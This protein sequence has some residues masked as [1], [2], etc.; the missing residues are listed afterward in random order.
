MFYAILSGLH[1]TLP[2]AELRGILE[3]LGQKYRI[4]GELDLLVLYTSSST[5]SRG[6]ASRAG[7]VHETGQVITVTEAEI[8]SII[9]GLLSSDLCSYIA[10]GDRVRIELLRLRG[11]AKETVPNNAAKIIA[12]HIAPSLEKC[13]A[14]T[15][16]RDYTK[17]MR[18]IVSLGATVVGLLEDEK[19][20]KLLESHK[21]QKRPFFHP[22]SLDPRLA[23]LF[24]NLSRARPPGP[25]LDP[26]CG[27]GG[28]PLEAQT[29][30]IPSICGELAGRLAKGASKNLKAYPG[31]ENIL[32]VAQ[33]DSARIPLRDESVQSI[34]T[35]PPYGRSVSLRGRQLRELLEDFI[36]EAARVLKRDS[37]IAFAAPH[38][39]E[40]KVEEYIENSGLKLLELHYMRVHGSLTRIITVAKKKP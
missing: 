26:F 18:V 36:T 15:T 7:L 22:G 10:E 23:R 28:F 17:R 31:N 1:P 39:A 13:G 24:V 25:Y 11:Y 20:D 19:P 37:Y 5:S 14:K 12:E 8:S 35:D 38:W 2:L 32:T 6:V 33:W 27:T 40:D 4:I 21:P 16:P 30:G 34:G 29:I 3:A 9:D